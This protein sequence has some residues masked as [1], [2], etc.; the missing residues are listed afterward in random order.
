GTNVDVIRLFLDGIT[1]NSIGSIHDALTIASKFHYD[2]SNKLDYI[3]QYAQTTALN[4][5]ATTSM[6][7]VSGINGD[8]SRV[9]LDVVSGNAIGSISAD[10]KTV[11]KYHYDESN[12]LDYIDQYAQ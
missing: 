10:G 9:F 8:F 3:D 11:S 1:V 2:V 6:P 5:L 12:K 7:S 4:V